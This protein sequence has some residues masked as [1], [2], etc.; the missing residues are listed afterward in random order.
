VY[1]RQHRLRAEGKHLSVFSN[2]V[3]DLNSLMDQLSLNFHE[4]QM[5]I[6]SKHSD[7]LDRHRAVVVRNSL[8]DKKF[9]FKVYM[10]PE[11]KLREIRYNDVKEYLENIKDYGLNHAMDRFFNS[12]MRT[13]G[14]GWTA[15]IYLNDPAD[16]MMFQLRFNND[17][18]KIEE[19][20]LISSL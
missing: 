13:R 5:P 6:N 7:I 3:T 16:L 17:I 19:A 20:V 18:Q 4:I 2:D 14:I 11:Y 1:K 10:K 15:A 8:F 12:N 9:K